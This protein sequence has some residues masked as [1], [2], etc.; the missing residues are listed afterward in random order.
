MSSWGSI[1]GLAST[2]KSAGKKL[3]GALGSGSPTLGEIEGLQLTHH[4]RQ[5]GSPASAAFKLRGGCST[6]DDLPACNFES[7]LRRGSFMQLELSITDTGNS[8]CVLRHF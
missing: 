7:E 2:A 4:A 6:T 3:P 5:A 8:T 1:F